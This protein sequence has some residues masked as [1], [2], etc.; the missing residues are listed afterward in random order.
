MFSWDFWRCLDSNSI[1]MRDLNVE[2]FFWECKAHLSWKISLLNNFNVLRIFSERKICNLGY[3]KYKAFE[4]KEILLNDFSVLRYFLGNRR[5]YLRYRRF[6]ILETNTLPTPAGGGQQ[7]TEF[8]RSLPPVGV[9]EQAP[10]RPSLQQ[11]ARN[12]LA[13]LS[14]VKLSWLTWNPS[15]PVIGEIFGHNRLRPYCLQVQSVTRWHPP[16]ILG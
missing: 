15:Y 3:L 11:I 8:A 7:W 5:S 16:I 6:N 10:L 2:K 13:P 4:V 12:F 9:G 14:L 1:Y